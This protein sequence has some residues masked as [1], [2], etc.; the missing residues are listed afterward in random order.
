[1]PPAKAIEFMIELRPG[2]ASRA[3]SLY[4]MSW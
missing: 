1:M 3:K 4:R 2:T